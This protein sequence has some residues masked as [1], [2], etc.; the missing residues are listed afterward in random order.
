MAQRGRCHFF[1]ECLVLRIKRTRAGYQFDFC[2]CPLRKSHPKNVGAGTV[3]GFQGNNVG[4]IGLNC[5]F[6][7]PVRIYS[8]RRSI[9]TMGCGLHSSANLSASVICALVISAIGLSLVLTLC[10]STY[11]RREQDRE[12]RGENDRDGY[13]RPDG[14]DADPSRRSA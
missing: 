3:G 9:V 12:K 6:W 5:K 13:P 14:W 7:Q 4:Q 11:R 8:A 10:I 1:S 2:H